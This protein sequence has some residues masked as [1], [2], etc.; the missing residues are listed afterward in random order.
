MALE[1]I[2]LDETPNHWSPEREEYLGRLARKIRDSEGMVGD[3]LV[4]G[5]FFISPE[6]QAKPGHYFPYLLTLTQIIHNPGTPPDYRLA[7]PP[8]P[9]PS[10]I[11]PT[12]ITTDTELDIEPD[13]DASSPTYGP[14]IILTCEEP[15]ARYLSSEVQSRLDEYYYPPSRSGYMISGV[16]LGE[17]TEAVHDLKGRGRYVF[18]TDLVDDFYESFG[19]S[20]NEF[21]A[22]VEGG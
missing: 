19:E 8:P 16:P 3:R 14:D 17:I 20:W 18:A 10:T 13:E 11:K 12:P 21:V 9:L 4:S 5:D 6:F 7:P 2:L 15:H 22:A 1:G